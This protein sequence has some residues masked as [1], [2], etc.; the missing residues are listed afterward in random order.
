MI[1]AN[2]LTEVAKF[3]DSKVTKIVINEE[4]EITSFEV[5]EV[6]QNVLVLNF[7]IESDKVTLVNKIDIVGAQNN[8][9]SSNVMDVPITTDH[10]MIQTI[11]VKEG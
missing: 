1:D 7:L 5:K 6:S 11:E 3:I 4:Y 2:L 8:I 10:I 9:I